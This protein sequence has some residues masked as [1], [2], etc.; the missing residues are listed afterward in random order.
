MLEII[1]TRFSEKSW[2]WSFRGTSESSGNTEKVLSWNSPVSRSAKKIGCFNLF[3]FALR[4][5]MTFDVENEHNT[6]VI[7]SDTHLYSIEN[8]V[9]IHRHH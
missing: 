3:L 1:K 5:L 4:T 8:V 9:S 6:K 2:P 7:D